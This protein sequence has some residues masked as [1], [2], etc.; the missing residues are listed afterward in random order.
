VTADLEAVDPEGNILALI[1]LPE[2]ARSRLN[3]ARTVKT[4]ANGAVILPASLGRT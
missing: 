1:R 2:V 3:S 4:R